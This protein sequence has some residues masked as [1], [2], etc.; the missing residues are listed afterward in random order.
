M[1]G[2]FRRFSLSFRK[3]INAV[4]YLISLGASLNRQGFCVTLGALA[5]AVP[6]LALSAGLGELRGQ[7]FLGERLDLSVAILGVDKPLPD[8]NCFRLVK[9]RAEDDLPWLMQADLQV[10]P[11]Q[12]PQL[13]VRSHQILREPVIR[14]A[15]Q[16]GCGHEVYREYVL[17]GSPKI[18]HAEASRGSAVAP[19]SSVRPLE[20]AQAPVTRSSEGQRSVPQRKPAQRK[21]AKPASVS[22]PV[23]LP[24]AEAV[25]D[26]LLL[27]AGDGE[28]A[29][30]LATVLD[31]QM[32]LSEVAEAQRDILRLEFQMLSALH[33]RAA[34]QLEAAEKLRKLESAL[35]DLQ[36]RAQ[37]LSESANAS[38]PATQHA[39]ADKP[40]EAAAAAAEAGPGADSSL[41]AWGLY[42]LLLGG[43]LGLVGWLFWRNRG[44]RVRDQDEIGFAVLPPDPLV[45]AP[46]KE[47][48]DEVLSVVDLQL[49]PAPTG[50]ESPVD[51]ELGGDVVEPVSPTVAAGR[52]GDSVLSISATTL[53][54]HFEANP[55][56]E[57]ADIMLS[58]GRVKGAAQALQEYVD[59][60]PSEA[61]QPWLRLMDVYR[62]AGMREEFDV[63]A[64]NL[65]QQFNVE[66]QPWEILATPVD[67]VLDGAEAVPGV[68]KPKGVEDMPRIMAS[69]VRMWAE[70]DV[71]GYMYQLLRDNRGGQRV[72]FPLPVVEE[73]LF[74]IELKETSNRMEKEK[75]V[76]T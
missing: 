56:M 36:G 42:G 48:V 24:V 33:E 66:I 46:R 57:L 75:A 27:S 15:L 30:R 62:M 37:A 73:V 4:E 54:E 65:N 7:P 76:Q 5:L 1:G 50:G 68:Q 55:V 45:D 40:V 29:L 3:I 69:I 14:V 58:F 25:G 74:L 21:P 64:R 44:G 47:E 67:L 23:P 39:S 41:S 71:V 8:A 22:T 61:L 34:S 2:I 26:R 63:L 6:G 11:G 35:G 38:L 60:N 31:E 16:L 51:V 59:N 28:S 13:K 17:L 10:L 18:D 32:L 19:E 20:T 43:V 72:G 12:V 49:E 70:E 53:D 9:P 52:P